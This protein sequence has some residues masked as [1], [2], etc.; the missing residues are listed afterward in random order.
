MEQNITEAEERALWDRFTEYS[1]V[2]LFGPAYMALELCRI[3]M[4]RKCRGR[5]QAVASGAVAVA[6]LLGAAVYFAWKFWTV[7]E[8]FSDQ[9][10]RL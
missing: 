6:G 7:I 10:L 5:A 3:M 1:T 4:G 8:W 2:W 9:G